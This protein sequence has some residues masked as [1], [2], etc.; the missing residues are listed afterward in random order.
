MHCYDAITG[1]DHAQRLGFVESLGDH[2]ICAHEGSS[3]HR[4]DAAHQVELPDGRL[5]R[6]DR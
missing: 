1:L 5:A 3:Q 6:A 4:S 2:G